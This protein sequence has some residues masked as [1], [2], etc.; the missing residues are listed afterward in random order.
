[1]TCW[2]TCKYANKKKRD[3]RWSDDSA[4]KRQEV[5]TW[6]KESGTVIAF[7]KVESVEV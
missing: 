7:D 3:G 5:Q 4:I 1:M 2:Q 6:N